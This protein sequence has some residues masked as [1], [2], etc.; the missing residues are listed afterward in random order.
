MWL[1]I[2]KNSKIVLPFEIKCALTKCWEPFTDPRLFLLLRFVILKI[3]I[4]QFSV[5]DHIIIIVLFIV[6]IAYFDIGI[7]LFWNI[8]LETL[9]EYTFM[10]L[11]VVHIQCSILILNIQTTERYI[12]Y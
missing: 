10:V 3:R 2:G 11:H 12:F 5:C 9:N 8:V 6:F 7:V 1:N 4:P